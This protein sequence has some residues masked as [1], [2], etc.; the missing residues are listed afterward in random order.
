MSKMKDQN[1]QASNARAAL[2]DDDA[3]KFL[4]EFVDVEIQ[5]TWINPVDEK[6][7]VAVLLLGRSDDVQDLYKG[8][9]KF[10]PSPKYVWAAELMHDVPKEV[11]TAFR[12]DEAV[13]AKK[14]SLVFFFE[15]K[16]LRGALMVAFRTHKPVAFQSP[17]KVRM[18]RGANAGLDARDWKFR[19]HP[20]AFQPTYQGAVALPVS[21]A[22]IPAGLLAA[23]NEFDALTGG[24]ADPK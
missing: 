5:R 1:V 15:P 9:E 12:G 17:G 22:S 14:G 7:A 13:D 2:V 18:K 21:E 6:P 19:T 4:G 23:A 24:A 20:N 8:N 16:V 3:A 11:G 10:A